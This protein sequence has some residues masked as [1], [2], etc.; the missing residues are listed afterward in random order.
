MTPKQWKESVQRYYGTHIS[1]K[2]AL[3]HGMVALKKYSPWLAAFNARNF[4]EVTVRPSLTQSGS[5]THIW[6]LQHIEIP[7]QYDGMEKPRPEHHI[8]IASFHSEVLVMSSMRR[9]KRLKIVGSDEKEHPW[10][11]KVG[12]GNTITAG[13]YYICLLCCRVARIYGWISESS[14]CFPS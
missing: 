1:G 14:S 7:G 6:I 5:L 13:W 8:T 12:M 11:I 4:E 9:P 10:L 3:P 2:E